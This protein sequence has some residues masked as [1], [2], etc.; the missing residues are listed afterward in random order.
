MISATRLSLPP[1][2]YLFQDHTPLPTLLHGRCIAAVVAFAPPILSKRQPRLLV[3]RQDGQ[4]WSPNNGNLMYRG[5][6]EIIK[7]KCG[8]YAHVTIPRYSSADWPN[9]TAHLI[10]CPPIDGISLLCTQ[11]RMS[12]ST[13]TSSQ[14]VFRPLAHVASLNLKHR[15]LVT[16]PHSVL[17]ACS[18]DHAMTRCIVT[19]S[20][21]SVRMCLHNLLQLR[22]P[23]G[24][25]HS[26]HQSRPPNGTST[27]S[28][29]KRLKNK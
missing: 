18:L 12:L 8:Y 24:H 9:A 11:N 1:V 25:R 26:R 2:R 23:N 19:F 22:S 4:I 16:Q 28:I 7:V 20:P 5:L 17:L 14:K 6:K 15:E 3:D 10:R 27:R 13:Q 29:L 21:A